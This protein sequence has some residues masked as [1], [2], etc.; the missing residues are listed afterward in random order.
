ML[1]Q[2]SPQQISFP[3]SLVRTKLGDHCSVKTEAGKT[4]SGE[5]GEDFMTG[6][7]MGW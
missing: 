2:N 5:G 1:P 3:F 6:Y 7:E 4:E